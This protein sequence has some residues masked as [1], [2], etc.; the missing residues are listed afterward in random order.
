MQ[1]GSMAMTHER[2]DSDAAFNAYPHAALRSRGG[3]GTALSVAAVAALGAIYAAVLAQVNHHAP[4]PYM[5][6][7]ATALPLPVLLCVA[8]DE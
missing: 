5:V 2:S 8:V 7:D 1:I 6:C 4:E 3:V